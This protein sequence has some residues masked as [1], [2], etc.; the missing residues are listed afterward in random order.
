M[1]REAIRRPRHPVAA[2]R[3]RRGDAGGSTMAA[4]APDEA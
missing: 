2:D 4:A 1:R 3:A